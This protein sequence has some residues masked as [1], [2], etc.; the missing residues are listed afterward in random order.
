[1][2]LG[3]DSGSLEK[4]ASSSRQVIV[5]LRDDRP[6]A[7]SFKTL[8]ARPGDGPARGPF[9]RIIASGRLQ[10]LE[11]LFPEASV[12]HSLAVESSTVSARERED[13]GLDGLNVLSFKSAAEADEAV[14]ELGHD[15][16]VE[17]RH[18]VQERFLALPR[19]GDEP[20]EPA[21]KKASQV[22]AGSREAADR[23]D[24]RD[25]RQWAHAAIGLF[26]ARQSPTFREATRITIAVIDSGVDPDHPDLKPVVA[27]TK[28][29]SKGSA[30]DE[31]GHGTHV[32]GIL[33][34]IPRRRVGV[35]GVSQSRRL[36]CLKALSPYDGP[37]YYRAL[38]HATDQGARVINLSLVGK[39][40]PTEELLVQH[41][42][43]AGA[44]VVAAMGNGHPKQNDPSYPAALKGVVAVGASTEIDRRASFSQTGRHICL[45]APGVN[46]LS[47]V[48]TYPSTLTESTEYDSWSGTS[49][50]TPFVAATIALLIAHKPD[51][52]REPIIAALRE[53][54]D[55]IAGQKGFS[56]EFGAGRLNAHG[57]LARL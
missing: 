22:K 33:A 31:S 38:R 25:N 55:R 10:S 7:H 43:R 6:A 34:A 47:T 2:Y 46:I 18:I 16:M 20:P 52:T 57:A 50:A 1:M 19:R 14:K 21:G 11:P 26:R 8:A 48:P 12:L 45:V 30:K 23:N 39:Y 17:Y 13:R 5:K 24:P 27:E 40:D 15:P 42:L 44:V 4:S 36:L 35:R 37:G 9:E 56:T 54:A 32:T 53:G 41:A 28:N 29:F 49:M 51:L 3:S